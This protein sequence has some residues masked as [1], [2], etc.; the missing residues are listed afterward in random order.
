MYIKYSL[1][2]TAINKRNTIYCV[3]TSFGSCLFCISDLETQWWYSGDIFRDTG[4][5]YRQKV[6]WR[7]RCTNFHLCE[8]QTEFIVVNPVT[9]ENWLLSTDLETG[10]KLVRRLHCTLLYTNSWVTIAFEHCQKQLVVRQE[11]KF[12]TSTDR[13]TFNSWVIF[14][15]DRITTVLLWH[16]HT[17]IHTPHN[18]SVI[19]LRTHSPLTT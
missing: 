11:L 2:R 3:L 17:H 7:P 1:F 4:L 12:Q 9:Q 14:S 13:D 18:S 5:L 6:W 15:E 16:F 10:H 19:D 8:K